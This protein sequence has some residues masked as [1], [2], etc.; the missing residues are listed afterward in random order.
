VLVELAMTWHTAFCEVDLTPRSASGLARCYV[1]WSSGRQGPSHACFFPSVSPPHR[2]FAWPSQVADVEPARKR[3]LHEAGK[4]QDHRLHDLKE[5]RALCPHSRAVRRGSGSRGRA[6]KLLEDCSCDLEL[7]IAAPMRTSA[8]GEAL[9]TNK[10]AQRI[11]PLDW[12]G[13]ACRCSTP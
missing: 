9:E 13:T 4:E 5:V 2:N 1:A 3:Y 6:R 7:E 12:P 11:V 10:T 8:L